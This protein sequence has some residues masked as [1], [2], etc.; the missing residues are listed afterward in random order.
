MGP[1]SQGAPT[2]AHYPWRLG[3]RSAPLLCAVPLDVACYEMT[4]CSWSRP[5]ARVCVGVCCCCVSLL[6]K[7]C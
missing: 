1:G 7:H 3:T 4:L 2:I 6:L 5:V